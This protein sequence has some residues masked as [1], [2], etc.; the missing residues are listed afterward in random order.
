MMDTSGCDGDINAG[1][2]R[3]FNTGDI[4]FYGCLVTLKFASTINPPYLSVIPHLDD[5]S[6]NIRYLAISGT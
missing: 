1:R 3:G 6:G 4:S 5:V 2:K